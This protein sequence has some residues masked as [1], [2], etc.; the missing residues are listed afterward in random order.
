MRADELLGWARDTMSVRAVFG[1]AYERDGAL[2]IPVARVRAAG[3]GGGGDGG[4]AHAEAGR[5][6][7]GGG[8]FEARPVGVYVIRDRQVS[9][10]PAFDA[11]SLA[12]AGQG[13]VIIA[14]LVGR[15][16]VRSLRRRR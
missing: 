13:A 2:V 10:Q 9:W 1:E 6:G 15:S 5:G 11:T 16:V 4:E 3:G 14:M 12:L 7:G 8:Y